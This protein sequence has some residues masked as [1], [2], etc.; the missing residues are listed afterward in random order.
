MEKIAEEEKQESF[1]KR[2]K[3]KLIGAGVLGAGAVAAERR[4]ASDLK[5]VL[6][7]VDP[8]E[9]E[10]LKKTFGGARGALNRVVA[11]SFEG[12]SAA[13]QGLNAGHSKIHDLVGRFIH[14]KHL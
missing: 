1:A 13:V 4:S 12:L 9:A 6:S 2:H 5:K 7:E 8:Q 11:G 3:K 14:R 10:Y